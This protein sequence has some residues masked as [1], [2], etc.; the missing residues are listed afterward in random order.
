M[1]QH[2]DVALGF[3]GGADRMVNFKGNANELLGIT[4]AALFHHDVGERHDEHRRRRAILSLIFQTRKQRPPR[5]GFSLG[6]A[7]LTGLHPRLRHHHEVGRLFQPGQ[8][9]RVGCFQQIR[10]GGAPPCFSDAVGAVG[11]AIPSARFQ[12]QR[13]SQFDLASQDCP[14][15]AYALRHCGN[16]EVRA[17]LMRAVL[18]RR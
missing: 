3:G 1:R 2:L 4:V 13:T 6:Q 15:I 10:Y 14:P 11:L 8:R 16:P 18:R 9:R 5:L 7:A 12:N 17:S